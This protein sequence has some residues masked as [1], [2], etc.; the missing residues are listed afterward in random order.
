[1]TSLGDAIADAQDGDIILVAP[2]E[3][4]RPAVSFQR[5]ANNI[6][7]TGKKI[8]I[9]GFRVRMRKRLSVRQ[10]SEIINIQLGNLDTLIPW[11]RVLP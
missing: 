2:G 3:N 9:S 7:L 6:V 1:M 5:L 4:I 10:C 8:T 11:S